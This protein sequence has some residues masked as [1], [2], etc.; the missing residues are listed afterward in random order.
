MTRSTHY[1]HYQTF[2]ELLRETRKKAGVTQAELAE[3]LGN[4]QVFV[5][6]LERAERRMDVIDLF[7]YCEAADIDVVEFVRQLKRE[8]KRVPRPRLGKLAVHDPKRKTPK[9]EASPRGRR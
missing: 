3:R 6:K 7:E 1:P 4:R 8:L 2:I 9:K 5:S